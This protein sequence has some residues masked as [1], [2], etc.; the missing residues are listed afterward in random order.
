[1]LDNIRTWVAGCGPVS[2]SLTEVTR[3]MTRQ[4]ANMLVR[5]GSPQHRRINEQIDALAA[6]DK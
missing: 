5:D 1:M 6:T 4:L 3:E 2:A